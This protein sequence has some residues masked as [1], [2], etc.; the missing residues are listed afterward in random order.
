MDER[1]GIPGH[2]PQHAPDHALRNPT[3]N[4][5]VQ[6][7][8]GGGGWD[9]PAYAPSPAPRGGTGGGGPSVAGGF[10]IGTGAPL[11]RIRSVPLAVLLAALLGPFGL[12]YLGLLNGIAALVILPPLVRTLA[13]MTARAY[14]GGMDTVGKVAIPILWAIAIPWAIIGVKIRNARA[15]R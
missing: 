13:F 11:R 12:F 6:N 1:F 5:P 14:G 8:G 4:D 3:P 7:I 10:S 9:Q 15:G 2:S